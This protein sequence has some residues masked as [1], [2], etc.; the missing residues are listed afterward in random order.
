MIKKLSALILCTALLFFPACGVKEKASAK[1]KVSEVT[2]SVFY[3][4]QYVAMAL[5]YFEDEGIEIELTNGQGADKVM[6]AL[7]SN[8][9]DIGF[10][11]PEAAIYVYNE[12]KEDY[13]KVFAQVTKRDGSFLMGRNNDGNFDWK[14]LKGKHILPGR[15]GGVPYMT[16]E[17]VIK[18]NGIDP[19]KDM[20]FDDSVQFSLMAGAF[21]A[22]T[23]DY[24]TLFEPTATMFQKE[25]KGYILAS[26]GEESGEIPYTAYYAKQSYIKENPEI[27][28]GFTKA[29]AKAQIWIKKNSPDEIAKTISPYFPDSDTELLTEVIKRYKDID[30]WCETPVMSKDSFD[31]LQNVMTEAGELSK[32]ADFE[33]LIDNSFCEKI[34]KELN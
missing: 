23:A 30:A 7:V 10:S 22:G 14:D 4:P 18:Q 3:A 9:I 12:G 21:A 8:S 19:H 5:G 28:E 25:G 15:K 24:V 32:K 27:I 13:P 11:G 6:T 31:R 1:V 29:I 33:K 26:V 16:L 17:Y 34:L 20:N 2:H